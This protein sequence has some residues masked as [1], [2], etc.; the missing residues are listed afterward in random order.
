MKNEPSQ[1]KITL[2]CGQVSTQIVENLHLNQL[3]GVRFSSLILTL[4]IIFVSILSC[5]SVL[6]N[7]IV[8]IKILMTCGTGNNY[9]EA[10]LFLSSTFHGYPAVA[11]QLLCLNSWVATPG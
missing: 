8:H 7:Q 2:H 9:V 11:M 3:K 1:L 10:V 6:S 5:N 4:G